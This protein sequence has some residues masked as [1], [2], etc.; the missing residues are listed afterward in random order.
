VKRLWDEDQT[1]KDWGF[2]IIRDPEAVNEEYES[3]KD[4][5]LFNAQIATGCGDTIVS[6]WTLQY[7]DWPDSTTLRR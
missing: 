4:G 3:K 2:A 6:R 1:E 7:L 5:A